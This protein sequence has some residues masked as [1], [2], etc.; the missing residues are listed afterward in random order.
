MG[1]DCECHD[2]LDKIGVRGCCFKCEADHDPLRNALS[3]IGMAVLKERLRL[4]PMLCSH[5]REG[6]RELVKECRG[7]YAHRSK[8]GDW[9][10]NC[11]AYV[12]HELLKTPVAVQ[13]QED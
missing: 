13:L 8:P 1:C 11:G 5:C 6:K 9:L 10:D 7:S 4:V 12:L 3:D 2:K